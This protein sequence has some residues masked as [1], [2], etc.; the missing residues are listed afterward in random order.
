MSCHGNAREC[1]HLHFTAELP[2]K[3][4]L[5]KTDFSNRRFTTAYIGLSSDMITLLGSTAKKEGKSGSEI[6]RKAID[7]YLNRIN[8]ENLSYEPYKKTS[9]TGL[10][11]LPRTISKDQD[12]RLRNLSEKTGRKMSELVREAVEGFSL[13]ETTNIAGEPNLTCLDKS[14]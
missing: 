2:H 6:L 9:P 5:I 14:S 4:P 10:K 1:L 3:K 8:W 13:S 12:A 11:V 7:S